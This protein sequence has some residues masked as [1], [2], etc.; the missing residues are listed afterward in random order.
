MPS[1]CWQNFAKQRC[2]LLF[3]D[4]GL[5]VMDGRQLAELARRLQT[6]AQS[7]V[8]DRVRP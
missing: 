6:V 7:A 8:H 2:D 5:P 4:I 1:M 3:T